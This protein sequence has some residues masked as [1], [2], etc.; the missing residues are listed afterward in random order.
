MN[1]GWKV[2]KISIR[3]KILIPTSVIIVLISALIVFFSYRDAEE[4]LVSL[5]VEKIAVEESANG[6]VNVTE[7]AANLINSVAHIEVQ[8]NENRDIAH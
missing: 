2:R 6:V 7:M 4:G 3:G 5:A 8:A 1:N